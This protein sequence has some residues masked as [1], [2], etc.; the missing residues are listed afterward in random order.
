MRIPLRLCCFCFASPLFLIFFLSWPRLT[1][2]SCP[3]PD[4]K[5][6]GEFFKATLVFTGKV[7]SVRK[8]EDTEKEIGG[9]FYRMRVTEIFRGPI[10]REFTVFTEDASN[11]FP[12]DSNGEYLLFAY[13]WHHRLLIDICGNSALLSEAGDSLQTLRDLR[14][15]KLPTEIE[16]DL[17][18]PNP[19]A[20]L[21]GVIVTIRSKTKIYTATTDKDGRFHRQLPPG[22]YRVDFASKEYYAQ[23]DDDFWYDPDHFYIH[24][25][26]CASLQLVSVRE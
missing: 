25:G 8:V 7:L 1:F 6:N 9:W 11:R 13:N 21:S 10:R 14:A 26:E 12:L 15:G 18:S 4:I 3:T 22:K 19:K 5:P 24:P 20:D 16:G 17:F 23:G 2:A